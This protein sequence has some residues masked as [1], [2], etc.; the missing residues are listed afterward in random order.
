[1][2]NKNCFIKGFTLVELLVVVLIIGILAA[3]ALPQYKKA[4]EKSKEAKV[5]NALRPIAQAAEQYFLANGT[6]ATSFDQ[7]DITLPSSTEKT[8]NFDNSFDADRIYVNG[9][10]VNL[11]NT[12]RLVRAS[13]YPGTLRWSTRKAYVYMLDDY[14]NAKKGSM[15]CYEGNDATAGEHCKG[16]LK[17]SD[18]HG[19]FYTF[20]Q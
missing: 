7:L 9:V 4:V 6:Y 19:R 11:V 3:I 20:S 15:L 17:K 12:P 1:M 2:K 14:G 18:A 8:C 13:V 5:L 16:T 10:C